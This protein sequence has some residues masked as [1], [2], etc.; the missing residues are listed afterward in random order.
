VRNMSAA[1]FAHL[2]GDTLTTANC[3]R[4]AR[5]DGVVMAW[6]DCN[7]PLTF[8]GMTY[9]ASDGVGLRN[10]KA[11]AG[12]GVDNMETVLLLMPGGITEDGIRAG[13]YDNAPVTLSL[14][15]WADLSQGSLTLLRGRVGEITLT[16]GQ[17]VAEVRS[18]SQL[19]QQQIGDVTSPSC[20]VRRLG[21]AQCKVDM[22]RFRFARMLTALG[23]SASGQPAQALTQ[24]N[25]GGGA[26]APFGADAGSSGGGTGSTGNAVATT[27]VTGAAPAD[28]YQTSR[29]GKTFSYALSGYTPGQDYTLR[30]HFAE[31]FFG[32]PSPPGG[33]SMTHGGG[34]G[35]RIFDV[36]ANGARVLQSIDIYQAAGGSNLATVQEL[37]VTADASGAL[38]IVFTASVDNASC[39]GLE[40][41]TLAAPGVPAGLVFAG[42]GAASGFYTHGVITFTSGA[43]AGLA[44]EI[45]GHG[46]AGGAAIISLQGQFPFAVAVGDAAILEAG[47]AR[48]L[49]TCV[50]K[51]NNA[52]NFR[53]ESLLPGNDQ[54]MRVGRGTADG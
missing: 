51:F 6:T 34:T 23:G 22:T 32:P 9:A 2:Q 25:C 4:L 48:R 36:A 46:L 16:D 17:C 33:P 49:P 39:C 27:G 20:R 15:N 21:D 1:L 24:T 12:T 52:A 14:V 43:N 13:L 35:S 37:E 50:E 47:C 42:D 28:V 41:L 3:V 54:V 44:R 11:A 7:I 26:A 30:L 45:K 8:D 38:H 31:T 5:T 10:L 19:L 40:V 53:G 29:Y 18:L